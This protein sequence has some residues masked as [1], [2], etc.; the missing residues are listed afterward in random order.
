M[1]KAIF[2]ALMARSTRASDLTGHCPRCLFRQEV[3]FCSLVPRVETRARFLIVRHIGEA[4]RTSN[5][6]RAAALAHPT[7]QIHDYGWGLPFDEAVLRQPGTWLLYPSEPGGDPSVEPP[8]QVVVL[9]ATWRQARKMFIRIDALRA[10]PR[11][12]LP[13]PAEPLPKLRKAPQPDAMSTLEAIVRAVELLEGTQRA[14]PL[15]ELQ[16]EIVRRAVSLRGF[17]AA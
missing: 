10:M 9:D 15:A 7:S 13:A 1:P 3:C 14:A 6:G 16:R 11:L 4:L 17:E 12:V 5:T 2:R 8:K